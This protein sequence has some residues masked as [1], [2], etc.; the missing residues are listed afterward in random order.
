MSSSWEKCA[1]MKSARANFALT[2]LQHFVYVYGG[3]SGHGDDD[4]SHHPTLANPIIERYTPQND[5]WDTIVISQV[6]SL[7]AFAWTPLGD[8]GKIA[9]L[10][11]TNGDII[12]EE[13]MIIDFKLETVLTRQTNFEFNT[14]QGKLVYSESK[15]TLYHIGGL[16]SEGV[17]YSLKMGETEWNEMDNNHSVLLNEQR[18]EFC[19]NTSIYFA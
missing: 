19:N 7:G 10:G 3:I 15:D 14:C 18:L 5:I 11:G 2:A 8:E 1:D 6:P 17:D 9:I 12:T 4:N 13:F 16:N